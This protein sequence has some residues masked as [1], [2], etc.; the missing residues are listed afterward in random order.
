MH[1][2]IFA[3]DVWLNCDFD[4]LRLE[5]VVHVAQNQVRLKYVLGA[6]F[7]EIANNLLTLAGKVSNHFSTLI[8]LTIA[9]RSEA[10]SV[11]RSFASKYLKF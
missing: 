11:K 9:E 10:K 7:S 4:Q 8:S 5:D 3:F 2:Q 1:S 6:R